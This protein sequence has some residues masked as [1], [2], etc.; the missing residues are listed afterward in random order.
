MRLDPLPSMFLGR[1]EISQEKAKLLQEDAK[2]SQENA[3]VLPENAKVFILFLLTLSAVESII[4][5]F[6][7]VLMKLGTLTDLF[8]SASEREESSK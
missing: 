2:V 5:S 3:K 1:T 6:L 8:R 7:Q 4:P